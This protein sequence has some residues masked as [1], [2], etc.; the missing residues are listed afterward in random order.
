MPR[1]RLTD[2]AIA[3]IRAADS[4]HLKR[5]PGGGW[6]IDLS[7]SK[8]SAAL[9]DKHD[10]PVVYPSKDSAKRAL[11]RHNGEISISVKPQL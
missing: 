8:G 9:V 11:G 10:R 5:V 1:N 6:N 3:N 2:Q 7:S 4:A